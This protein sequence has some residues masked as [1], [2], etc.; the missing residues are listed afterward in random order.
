MEPY[1]IHRRKE[2]SWLKQ[3]DKAIVTQEEFNEIDFSQIESKLS[4]LVGTPIKLTKGLQ[5]GR[6]TAR[7]VARSQDLID[8]AGI[9]KAAFKDV[10]V[11]TFNSDV[12]MGEEE[13]KY[14][15]ATWYLDYNHKGGGSNGA[16]ILTSWYYFDTK[17]WEFREQK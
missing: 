7:I 16:Q 14:W 6:T 10:V 12:A 1:Y 17:K 3:A 15:W 5:S 13:K 8:K 9:F 2:M 4:E 11:S